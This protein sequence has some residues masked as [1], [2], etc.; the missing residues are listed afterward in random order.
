MLRSREGTTEP[1]SGLDPIQAFSVF[2]LGLIVL[3]LLVAAFLAVYTYSTPGVEAPLVVG[4]T[5]A[6][7]LVVV[8]NVVRAGIRQARRLVAGR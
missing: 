5:L 4:I 8:L 7:S 1:A 3:G 6:F 2:V